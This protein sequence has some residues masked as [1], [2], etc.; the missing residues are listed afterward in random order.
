M[1]DRLQSKVSDPSVVLD[2]DIAWAVLHREESQVDAPFVAGHGWYC[3]R[4]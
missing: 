3:S 1:C 2:D 4:S